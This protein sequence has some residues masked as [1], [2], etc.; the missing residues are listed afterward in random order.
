MKKDADLTQIVQDAVDKQRL[1]AES[2]KGGVYDISENLVAKPCWHEYSAQNE[3]IIASI[4][5]E[6]GVSV[7]QPKTVL[8][9]S[10][11]VVPYALQ[12]NI[13]NEGSLV[14]FLVMQKISAK[15][16]D[17]LNNADKKYAIS[18]YKNE[19][20][21]VYQHGIMPGIDTLDN[22][23]GNALYDTTTKTIWLIDFEEW[24][25]TTPE[26]ALKDKTSKL[27]VFDRKIKLRK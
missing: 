8:Q 5:F 2:G 9:I 15:T 27:H 10:R 7:P 14:Y 3:Y 19:L 17:E 12:N 11:G 18:K 16:I 22:N 20:T 13:K 4:L 24:E 25:I 21:K 23:F 6:A 26:E 1:Y